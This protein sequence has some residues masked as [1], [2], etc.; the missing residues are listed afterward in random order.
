MI[1]K[2]KRLDKLDRKCSN[3]RIFH[4]RVYVLRKSKLKCSKK[5]GKLDNFK[6][7]HLDKLDRKCSNFR[8]F[9]RRVYVLSK[10]KLKCSKK[11]GKLDNFEKEASR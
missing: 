6:R 5:G 3:F 11:G 7:K 2:R 4:R 1:L 9:H 8:I 10:S